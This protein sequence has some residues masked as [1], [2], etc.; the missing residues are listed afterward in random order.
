MHVMVVNRSLV[1]MLMVINFTLQTDARLFCLS[2]LSLSLDINR[3][4]LEIFCFHFQFFFCLYRKRHMSWE[5]SCECHS[6]YDY[7]AD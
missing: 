7:D 2:L 6:I 3:S 5:E 1:I 4:T